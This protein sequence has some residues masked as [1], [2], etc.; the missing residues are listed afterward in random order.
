MFHFNENKVMKI[1]ASAD[2]NLLL[3]FNLFVA[4]QLLSELVTNS[5]SYAQ[6]VT[7]FSRPL[8][9][10]IVLNTWKDVTV[11]VMKQFLEFVLHKG[12]FSCQHTS[13]D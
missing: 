12:L 13:Q 6:K 9:I 4:D 8:R 2:D 10:K 7:S 3:F 5:N 11:T 1:N